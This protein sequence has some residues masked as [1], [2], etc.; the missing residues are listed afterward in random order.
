MFRLS[1]P[2]NEKIAS[3]KAVPMLYPFFEVPWKDVDRSKLWGLGTLR[4]PP[5][6]ANPVQTMKNRI[7]SLTALIISCKCLPTRGT[8]VCIPTANALAAMAKPL[9]FHVVDSTPAALRRYDAQVIALLA[10]TS[11]FVRTGAEFQRIVVL[12]TYAETRNR[13]NKHRSWAILERKIFQD[14]SSYLQI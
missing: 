10:D 7:K 12:K 9:S 4:W 2:W 13:T 8:K 1:Y 14:R 6:A 5:S 11:S 3:N